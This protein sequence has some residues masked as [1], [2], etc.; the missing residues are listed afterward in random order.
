[1]VFSLVARRSQKISEEHT[2]QIHF[3]NKKGTEFVNEYL[4]YSTGSDW[5]PLTKDYFKTE[6]KFWI[7][8]NSNSEI[9]KW[10]YNLGIPFDNI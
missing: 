8:E 7:T 5:S 2:D 10:L 4:N 3:L 9:K 1:M 6:N